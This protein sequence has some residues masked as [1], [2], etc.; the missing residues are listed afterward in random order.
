MENYRGADFEANAGPFRFTRPPE[1]K[2]S[3]AEE[4]AIVF[5]M[6]SGDTEGFGKLV[7]QY[8]HGIYKHLFYMIRN[9][10]DAEDLA[11][12]TF[13]NAMV[14][15]SNYEPRGVPIKSWFM[16]IAHNVGASH[17]RSKK[18]KNHVEIYD[19]IVDPR[20]SDFEED[21]DN[22]IDM[23]STVREALQTVAMLP[24]E[25]AVTI[26]MRFL[27]DASYED[28]ASKLEKSV[29]AV[30]AIQHRALKKLAKKLADVNPYTEG[31][32]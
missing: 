2:M 15:I 12:K 27:E 19:E 25:Q 14:A 30:R 6:K 17:L 32:A 7:E 5:G 29:P 26:R 9:H 10:H 23:Q 13:M 4:E 11:G 22:T 8:G 31:A 16:R 21:V 3:L 1:G 24:F 18:E 28:V 20:T